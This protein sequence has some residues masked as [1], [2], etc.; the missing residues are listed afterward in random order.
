MKLKKILAI[1]ISVAMI[2]NTMPANVYADTETAN[3]QKVSGMCS[4]DSNQTDDK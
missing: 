2:A 4:I 3:T 1:G